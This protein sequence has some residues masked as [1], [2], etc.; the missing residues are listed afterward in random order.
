[1]GFGEDEESIAHLVL[2]ADSFLYYN[3]Y[4]HQGFAIVADA[5][6]GI[7]TGLL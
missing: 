4:Q 6:L 3:H 7:G 5:I 1:M 2:Y